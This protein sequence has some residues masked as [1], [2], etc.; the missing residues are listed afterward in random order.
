MNPLS[1][2]RKLFGKPVR[3]ETVTVTAFTSTTIQARGRSGPVTLRNDGSLYGIGDV[4][5]VR[6]STVLGRVA[7]ETSLPE[8]FI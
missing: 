6:E 1:E 3:T 2:L 8:Y 4:L 7:S 5:L